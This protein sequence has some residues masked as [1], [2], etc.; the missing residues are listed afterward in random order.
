MRLLKYFS[1]SFVVLLMLSFNVYA[2]DKCSD[3]KISELKKQ[4]AKV[5]MVS[6]FDDEGIEDGIFGRYIVTLYELP[7]K[8]YVRSEDQSVLFTFDDLNEGSAS[9]YID[10]SVNKFNIFSSECP[11]QSLKKITLDLKKYNIYYGYNEC[12]GIEEGELDVCNKFYDKDITY[13]QFVKAV[14]KYKS[15]KNV[16]VTTKSNSFLKD[17]F[18]IISVLAGAFIFIL[19]IILFI[20]NARKNKLD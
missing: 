13:S 17:N 11:G 7:Q 10:Y 2:E 6:Q 5:S 14:E 15:E 9:K 20:V 1:F 8:F 3:N 18:V 4:I 12:D 19:I 16:G